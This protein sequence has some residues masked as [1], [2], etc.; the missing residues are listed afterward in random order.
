VDD[1]LRERWERLT[2]LLGVPDAAAVAVLRDLWR[3]HD[4]PQRV[5]HRLSHVRHVLDVIDLLRA[6][7]QVE[8]PVAVQLAAWF[9]DAVY[10]PGMTDNEVRSAELATQVLSAWGITEERVRHVA[11][12]IGATAEHAADGVDTDTGV[13]IDADMAILAADPVTYE[14]YR[15]AVRVEY[16]TLDEPTWR[17]GRA[18]FLHELL[19][20]PTIFATRSMRRRGEDAARRNLADE[21]VLLAG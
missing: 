2:G 15:R 13:L 4:E 8:D 19:D 3:R 17:A 16:Q 11:A 7:E 9:H 14:L 5:Y 21:L 1:A 20:R 10:E 12:L 18:D 6:E